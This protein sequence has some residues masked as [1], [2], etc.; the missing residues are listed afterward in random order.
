MKNL[1]FLSIIFTFLITSC[2]TN[3]SVNRKVASELAK[4]RHI[5]FLVHGIAAGGE[6]FGHM[7][8]A[9][10]K[11]LNNS[12]EEVVVRNFVYE[13]HNN[14]NNTEQFAK[15]LGN[16][17]NQYFAENGEI[18]TQDKI[19]IIAHSQG[20]IVSLIWLYR[21]TIGDE[22]FYPKYAT[23]MDSYITLGTPYW[24]AKIAVFGD[25]IKKMAEKLHKDFMPFFGDQQLEDMSFGSPVIFNF[26]KNSINPVFQEI[27][28]KINLRVRPIN[29]GGAATSIKFLTPFA[30][31]LKEYEDDSAVPLPSSHFDF[32]YASSLKTGYAPNE[33]LPAS[34]FNETHFAPYHVI[35]AL[36]VSLLPA[37]PLWAAMANIPK[38]CVQSADCNHPSFKYILAHL[39]HEPLVPDEKLLS[40]MT[41]YLLDISVR[42]PDGDTLSADKIKIEFKS[43][44]RKLKVASP[45]E[46]FSHGYSANIENESYRHFYFTGTSAKSFIPKNLRGA[47][48]PFKDKIL[49]V[50]ISA[51]GYK[52]RIIEAKVRPTYST[53]I[54]INLEK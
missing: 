30:A 42:L 35:D 24:G 6:T 51:P 52:T 49:S 44:D 8:E 47:G 4:P 5:I 33:T 53:F 2:S 38:A 11:H 31:G 54:D 27:L 17:I 22:Q 23:H 3:K 19:S 50:K 45:M 15:D 40:K 7:P 20:G 46:F 12:S 29:F 18:N 28:S 26:R 21:A 48:A 43:H 39:K 9:L 16:S 10:T 14:K 41:A 25:N 36:H 34:E 13:T 1:T 32:I 37:V